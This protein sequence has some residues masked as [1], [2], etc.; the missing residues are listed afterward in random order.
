MRRGHGPAPDHRGHARVAA[1]REID[2]ER[3]RTRRP[4]GG[5]RR[6]VQ[7]G[8]QRAGPGVERADRRRV[9]RQAARGI[10][11][12]QADVLDDRVA[13]RP[14]AGHHEEARTSPERELRARRRLHLAAR[15]RRE[16]R[17]QRREQ[18]GGVEQGPDLL[19][20]EHEHVVVRTVHPSGDRKGPAPRAEHLGRCTSS[21]SPPPPPPSWTP[22]CAIRRSGER[23]P[24][25]FTSDDVLDEL[26]LLGQVMVAVRESPAA[27]VPP[28][29]CRLAPREPG[30]GV[31]LGG[32]LSL[33]AAALRC[34]I[35]AEDGLAGEVARG[36]ADLGDLLDEDD[37]F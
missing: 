8:A 4:G 36:L 34:L 29:T 9:R 26:T 31:V 28:F 6:R 18:R 20:T 13:A 17:G 32:G 24:Q 22:C 3:R 5:Q 30:A 2:R 14:V 10:A 12:E 1:R 11:G 35:E 25:G 7:D 37:D 27:G 23:W 33:T 21:R 16:R 19:R 15:R